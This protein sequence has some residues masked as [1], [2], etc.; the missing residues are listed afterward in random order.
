VN[1]SSN[2]LTLC[3]VSF[4]SKF[5]LDLNWQLTTRLNDTRDIRWLVV[6]NTDDARE[7]ALSPNDSRFVVIPGVA[8][9]NSGHAKGSYHHA[10]ALNKALELI[11]TRY[12]LF[13]DPDFFIVQP[14][15]I[16]RVCEYVA[17]RNLAFWGAPYYPDRPTKYRYFPCGICFL[18]DLAR[19]PREALDW[20][21]ELYEILALRELSI[22]ALLGWL[23][24]GKRP[25]EQQITFEPT[26]EMLSYALRIRLGWRMQKQTGQKLRFVKRDLGYRIYRDF[27]RRRE[28]ARE[29]LMPVWRAEPETSPRWAALIPD[30]FS[31][32]PKRK[33]YATSMSFRDFGLP[34]VRGLDWEEYFWRGQP[35]A[36]HVRGMFQGTRAMNPSDLAQLVNQFCAG[37]AAPRTDS[38]AAL[39]F[40]SVR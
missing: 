36:F 20:T 15:W 32:T 21:P 4:R 34:D 6:E 24:L 12:V 33:D 26:R 16:P 29:C 8:S 19:V 17:A 11:E 35:F 30:D 27:A 23:I 3:S 14:E 39:Q 40:A 13:L 22:R 1:G 31:L 2:N 10:A 5:A 18:V 25:A 38:A 28:Y 9:A 7:Q 37:R